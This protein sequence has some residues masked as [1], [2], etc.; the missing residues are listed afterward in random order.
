MKIID[1][2]YDYYDY[3][4]SYTDPIVFDRRGSF[5]LTRE[6]RKSVV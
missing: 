2:Q 4:Q 1:N 5:L 6:D 3:L